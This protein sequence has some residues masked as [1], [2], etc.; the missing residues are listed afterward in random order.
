MLVVL[1]CEACGILGLLIGEHEL[2]IGD[3][4]AHI[5][6]NVT[7]YNKVVSL[8]SQEEASLGKAAI[9]RNLLFAFTLIGASRL[10]SAES[11]SLLSQAKPVFERAAKSAIAEIR[12]S[13][14]AGLNAVLQDCYDRSMIKQDLRGVQYCFAMHIAAIQYDM[15]VIE[16]LGGKGSSEGM[17]LADAFNMAAPTLRRA[18]YES[19]GAIQSVLQAW[20][21]SFIK[22]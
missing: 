22:E 8:S 3:V 14:I 11:L 16:S 19:A 6:A 21:D 20:I 12:K 4:P 15:A 18:G 5:P 2:R 13:G 10:A 9:L 1:A 7:K 17:D